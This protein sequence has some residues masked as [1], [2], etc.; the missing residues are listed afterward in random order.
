MGK[1]L[2]QQRKLV[3]SN[4]KSNSQ[5]CQLVSSPVTYAQIEEILANQA[6]DIWSIS[7]DLSRLL[8]RAVNELR[9]V[10]V[11]EFG[12][13]LSSL[14]LATALSTRS[15]GQLT[16]VEQNPEWCRPLWRE[17]EK[18]SNVD[19]ELVGS[20]LGL[21]LG[22]AGL[23]Y[24]FKHAD[25]VLARRGPYDLVVVDAPQG[26]YSRDGALHMARRHLSP[27]ALIVLD[28]YRWLQTYLGLELTFFDPAF[29]GRGVALLRTGGRLK[30]RLAIMAALG[31]IYHALKYRHLRRNL[32]Y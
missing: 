16:S 13:G 19:A 22:T 6:R 12:A 8:A 9:L 5:I 3:L 20:D 25:S 32:D 10:N 2:L 21:R 14:T 11:L 1:L 28:L 4:I 17:V 18:I 31:S 7:D 26:I 23:Y 27:H 30:S 15:G 24:W 29:G